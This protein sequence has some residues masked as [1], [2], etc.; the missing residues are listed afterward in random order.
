M[1]RILKVAVFLLLFIIGITKVNAASFKIGGTPYDSLNEAVAAAPSD[2][3]ETLIE[4]T[5]DVTLAPGVQVTEGKN[6]IIDF[7]GHRFETWE[8]MVGSKGT[9]T[10]SFQLLKGSKVTMKN[11][12]LIA[13]THE[14][15]KMFIQNYA[16][17]TLENVKIDATTNTYDYFYAVSSNNGKVNIIGNTSI[18]VNTNTH[19]RAFDMCWAP[20]VGNASYNGGTQ[21]VVNTTGKVN[22]IIEL[23]VWG[24]YTDVDGIKST[25]LI[26]NIDFD[27][28]WEIDSRLKNQLSIEGGSFAKTDTI[29]LD[30]YVTGSNIPYL[31]N[32][33]YDVLPS[34]TLKI[35]EEEIYVTKGNIYEL[36][37][38][39]PS[40]YEKYAS[41][42]VQ[43]TSI[44]TVENG[45]LTAKA[46]GNTTL[47]ISF[48]RTGASLPITVYEVK[49]ENTEEVL[50]EASAAVSEIAEDLIVDILS[51]EEV[52]GID[53]ATK[54]KIIE[55][56]EAGK[57]IVTELEASEIKEEDIDEEVL[58]AIK[59]KADG[60]IVGFL[61]IDI[62]FKADGVE[63]GNLTK[64]PEPIEI[65]VEV[66]DK[67]GE[68]PEGKTRKFYV[69]RMHDGEEP[70]LLEATYE[71]GKLK[72]KTDRFSTY[73]YGYTDE[74]KSTANPKTGDNLIIFIIMFIISVTGLSVAFLYG[75][76]QVKT[77][78]K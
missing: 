41:I 11:G 7:G 10:Q 57:T 8:P 46:K 58:E 14:L 59:E 52:E 70:E 76:K 65:T 33:V 20:L 61:N 69:V 18:L 75:K 17:L 37:I 63:L 28:K 6:L 56:V 16:D 53:E 64:L 4:M 19:A 38:E 25:L 73:A 39:I 49:A 3:T 54:A 67:L 5:E 13:S 15:S 36:D 42:S 26:K 21:M 31:S 2:G 23:D 74:A 47:V 40:G 27:G 1:K 34:K 35:N 55:A 60:E 62:L 12:T 72:F 32:N 71:N 50:D 66:D 68:I 48:G 22:G 30:E 44:A 51:E 45:V 29:D 9:E 78:Q 77:T 43:D 24:S